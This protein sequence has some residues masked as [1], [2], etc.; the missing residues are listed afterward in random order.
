MRIRRFTAPEMR[1]AIRAVRDELGPNAVIL[2]NRKVPE[3]V[4]VVAAIDYS[5]EWVEDS[6]T[7]PALPVAPPPVEPVVRAPEPKQPVPSEALASLDAFTRYEQAAE[8]EPVERRRPA[9]AVARTQEP[10]FS[11][12]IERELRSLR[13]L[14][15]NQVSSLAW[16]DFGRRQPVRAALVRRLMQLG[17]TRTVADPIAANAHTHARRDVGD[18]EALWRRALG[19]LSRRIPISNDDILSTGGVVALV[20]PTGVG[21]TTTIAKLAARFRISNGAD[22][23]ALLTTDNYRVGAQEQLRSYAQLLGLPFAMCNGADEL[24]DAVERYRDRRLILIDTAGMSQRDIRLAE[25]A[26][27][28]EHGAESAHRDPRLYLVLSANTN[29][30][31]LEETVEAFGDVTLDGCIL[32]KIDEATSLGGALSIMLE[33]ALPALHTCDGQRVPEDLH[34]ADARQLV[35]RATQFS[36]QVYERSEEHLEMAYAGVAAHA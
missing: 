33:H 8:R 31:T 22:S 34:R 23:A 25:Q 26:R 10:V 16:G 24:R 15:E 35:S 29:Y 13:G 1:E 27:L 28:I 5:E 30:P 2:S 14:L 3:G 36:R 17:L 18:D 4:E 12:A 19:E 20:G 6:V 7:A 21:K 32:T 9:P 11:T